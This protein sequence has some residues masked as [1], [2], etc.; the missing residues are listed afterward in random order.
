MKYLLLCIFTIPVF[1]NLMDSDTQSIHN[2]EE[3][4]IKKRFGIGIS[5]GGPLSI[6]G[7]EADANLTPDISLSM[8][9][10]TGLAYSTF[11]VKTRFFLPG[12][13]V[14]PYA[15]IGIARWWTSGTASTDIGPSVLVNKFLDGDRD[16]TKGFN[17]WILYP[18]VGVQFM[19]ML[20]FSFFAEVEY[21]FRLFNFS[22]GT[23][24]GLGMHWY[25]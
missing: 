2:V 17:V 18:A 6:L 11:M 10:G 8:G 5:G 23:Y 25:F 9:L 4:K 1:A 3:L 21:L 13:W 7:L 15:A 19:H 20:G 14:S 22:S 12:E 24:A 16:Y